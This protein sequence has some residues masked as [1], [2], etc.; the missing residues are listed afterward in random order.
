M[1]ERDVESGAVHQALAIASVDAD[2]LYSKS[3]E[4]DVSP[5]MPKQAFE[6]RSLQ[7]ADANHDG[8]AD[9]MFVAVDDQVEAGCALPTVWRA[10]R[11]VLGDGTGSFAEA[12]CHPAL[13]A[14]ATSF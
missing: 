14:P 1:V 3:D 12:A 7:T 8:H 9:L 10:I 2:G 4:V 6:F 5:L 11:L 13:S